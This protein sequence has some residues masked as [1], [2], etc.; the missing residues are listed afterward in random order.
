MHRN[1]GCLQKVF[2]C[3]AVIFSL[4]LQSKVVEAEGIDF[5]SLVN[6]DRRGAHRPEHQSSRRLDRVA[7][8]LAER[9]VAHGTDQLPERWLDQEMDA[10]GYRW[11]LR[12]LLH[13]ANFPDARSFARAMRSQA[14]GR[15]ILASPLALDLAI[16]QREADERL[17]KQGIQNIWVAVAALPDRPA[18]DGWRAA[19]LDEV[20]RFRRLNALPPLTMNKD[21][22][23]AAQL[24]ADNMAIRDFFAHRAPDGSGPGD[25]ALRSG[26]RYRLVLE[27]LAAGQS[28]PH[29]VVEGWKASKDGHREAMLDPR[30]TEVGIGYRYNPTDK[31]RVR[32]F[33][34][35][36]MT[37]GQPRG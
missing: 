19:V 22:N 35:W 30:P 10:T 1:H 17:R 7:D 21:L 9:L 20:N 8:G 3:A 14:T 29:G 34:Y 26:Y 31:G 18:K 2:I 25:R 6:L 16:S 36:A 15:Q 37:M 5:L 27:N 12:H 32:Y 13:G 4:M 23:R 24:H 28:T 33:H 11:R